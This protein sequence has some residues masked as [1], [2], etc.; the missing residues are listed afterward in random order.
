MLRLPPYLDCPIT[1][2]MMKRCRWSERYR[3][4]YIQYISTNSFYRCRYLSLSRPFSAAYPLPLSLQKIYLF[5]YHFLYDSKHQP[6]A[7]SVWNGVQSTCRWAD[8][9]RPY[10]K[11]RFTLHS[12]HS[13]VRLKF[14]SILSVILWIYE[15]RE[16]S[17][18]LG[19]MSVSNARL[20]VLARRS[21]KELMWICFIR[22]SRNTLACASFLVCV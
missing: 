21:Y 4:A 6:P 9:L 16:S 11:L 3:N 14:K 15:Y 10:A 1:M 18:L 5:I 20:H 22:C 17:P 7:L 19:V 13:S 12:I 2:I 8:N